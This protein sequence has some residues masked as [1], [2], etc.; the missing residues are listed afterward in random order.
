MSF[1]QLKAQ[2]FAKTTLKASLS[3]G[4]SASSYL[5]YGPSGCGKK[6]AAL[7]LAQALE[8]PQ[9]PLEGCGLCRV[10]RRI[11][12]HKHPDVSVFKPQ[13]QSFSVEQV[14]EI[15]KE[16]ALKPFEGSSKVYILDQA[17]V[18][19]N[20]AANALL[21]IIEEP[22]KGLFFILVTTQKE[23]L[24]PTIL[25]RCQSIR[26]TALAP[27][28]LAEILREQK[29][30]NH[31]EAL[32]IARLA[33][34]SYSRAEKLVSE[35]GKQLVE[36]AESFLRASVNDSVIGRLN[37]AHSA[38]MHKRDLDFLLDLLGVMLRDLWVYHKSFPQNL[39][40]RFDKPGAGLGLSPL[41]LEKMLNALDWIKG[42]LLSNLSPVYCLEVFSLS[43]TDNNILDLRG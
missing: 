7:A 3:G 9:K 28:V 39:R 4:R 11:S 16:A 24:L 25:S 8:C 29:G 43:G 19:S 38:V 37:W 22:Q 15:L 42:A 5:F 1:E 21:K 31:S 20:E 33:Y 32:D 23:S 30:L 18:L 6:T 14:R 41:K 40:M 34:G 27:E 26:F 13:K 17:E 36:L 35:E 2:N 10:C 12:E